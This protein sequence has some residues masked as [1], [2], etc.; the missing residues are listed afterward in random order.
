MLFIEVIDLIRNADIQWTV[1]DLKAAIF[2]D[3][4]RDCELMEAIV[5]GTFH[6]YSLVKDALD[7]TGHTIEDLIAAALTL[8]VKYPNS[9]FPRE[10]SEWA[11][12]DCADGFVMQAL[13]SDTRICKRAGW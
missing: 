3:D 10:E 2:A 11:I 1:Q 5:R 9:Y 4:L 13:E 12:W 8:M 6:N 7:R